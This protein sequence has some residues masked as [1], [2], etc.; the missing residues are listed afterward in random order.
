LE[1]FG[2]GCTGREMKVLEAWRKSV[3]AVS[4]D[5]ARNIEWRLK[6]E[7]PSAAA[8]SASRQQFITSW[9]AAGGFSAANNALDHDFGPDKDAAHI[10]PT[11]TYEGAEGKSIKWEMVKTT[12]G[13]EQGQTW[14][15]FKEFCARRGL[16]QNN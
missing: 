4:L 6:M 15:D 3:R 9:L 5:T 7:I 16:P 10:D 1:A 12:A 11:Q 14:I 2:I 13:P 8:A